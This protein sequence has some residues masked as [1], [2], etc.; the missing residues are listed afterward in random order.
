M[1][2]VADPVADGR[3]FGAAFGA[4]SR[5]MLVAV[6]DQSVDCV[7]ILDPAGRIEFMNRNGLCAME[8]DDIAAIVDRPWDSLWPEQA[9]GP[10]REALAAAQAGRPSR[11]DAFCPTAKGTPK[12]WDV[13]VSP[14][15]DAAGRTAAILSTSRDVTERHEAHERMETMAHEMRHRLRNAFAIGGAIVRASGREA[16]EHAEFA[17]DLARRLQ[18]LSA[19][20]GSLID[21]QAGEPLGE[22]IARLLAA[23]ESDGERIAVAALPAVTLDEQ[24]A[25]L[26]ALVVGELATNSLK[27]GALGRGQA[28]SLRGEKEGG[29]L[30]LDWREAAPGAA[31]DRAGSGL[32]LMQR[33]ARAHGG[34]FA[35]RFDGS[36]LE[37]RLVVPL[38]E[39][40]GG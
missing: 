15:R 36:G 32:A 39:P 1:S 30:R 28:V 9:R 23:F 19:A 12:W 29:R 8:I 11:F 10:V 3:E 16:P 21:P 13:S 7:K 14:V 6:L 37:A 5:E 22:L 38:G 26:V 34:E 40:D 25:R 24:Q 31:A 27:H 33:M 20:Q 2:E 35:A 18:T 17:A 4:L